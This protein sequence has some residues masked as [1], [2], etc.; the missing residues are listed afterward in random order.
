M[1]LDC[2]RKHTDTGKT[3]K[4]HAESLKQESNAGLLA[5]GQHCRSVCTYIKWIA[6]ICVDKI[7]EMIIHRTAFWNQL[8]RYII[9]Y[10]YVNV[11]LWHCNISYSYW[12]WSIMLVGQPYMCKSF[13]LSKFLLCCFYPTFC[14]STNIPN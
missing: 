5:V 9:N 10:N 2:E 11:I 4:H 7:K 6:A 13:L 14:P 8:E 12:K 3:C 1:S